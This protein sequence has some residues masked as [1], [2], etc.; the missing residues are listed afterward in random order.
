[1]EGI[2]VIDISRVLAGPYCAQMLADFGAEVIKVESPEGDEN[3]TWPP[4]MPS[5]QSCN[6]ASVNRGK[7]SITLNLKAPAARAVIHRLVERA[8]VL[9]HSFLPRTAERLGITY[10]ALRAINPRLIFCSI[11]GYGAEGEQADKGGYDLMVQAFTGVMSATGT[12]D[13]PP[14]RCGV[15][16]IDM[17]TGL[18]AYGGILTA[19][20]ARERTGRGTWVRGSLMETSV[21]LLGYHAVAWLQAG[22]LPQPQGSGTWHLVP[23]QA[24]RCQDGYMLAGAP[25]DAAWLRFCD[26][27]DWPELARDPR[28]AGNAARVEQREV[29]V[30]LLEERFMRHPVAHWLARFEARSVACSPLHTLD[31]VL[32]HPQVLANRM[33]VQATDADGTQQALLGTPFKLGEGGGTAPTAP[34]ALGADTDAVMEQV[35]GFT[36]AEIAT[37]RAA[38][39]FAA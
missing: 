30:P 38:G 33:V 39:S 10:D 8:D 11:S 13:G 37:L 17:S 31:Q 24:F 18:A 29:L 35:L 19:L 32:T 34:P 22:V 14:I 27:L 25:N 3:R 1:L 12:V 28:F 21:A 15:S 6:F 5:G 4:V 16:F 9:L 20:L 7:R 26:A 23:Y 2:R 36:A